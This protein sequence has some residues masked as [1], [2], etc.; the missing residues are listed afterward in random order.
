MNFTF[1]SVTSHCFGFVITDTINQIA[2]YL[3]QQV[4]LSIC[5][6]MCYATEIQR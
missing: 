5:L 1:K 3:I 6:Q 4:Y 2:Y